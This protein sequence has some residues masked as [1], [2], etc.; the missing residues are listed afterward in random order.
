MTQ[1]NNS[2]VCFIGGDERQKYAAEALSEYVNVNAVGTAF[3]NIKRSNVKLFDNA[4]KAIYDTSAIILPLPAASSESEVPFA[5]LISA[6]VK[7]NDAPYIIGGKFSP[8]LKEIIEAYGINYWDYY[9]DEC[10]TLKNAFLTAEGAVHL[11]M[12]STKDA[13]RSSR[14][15]I[16]GYGRI[17]KALAEML[18]ALNSDTTVWARREDALIL[19]KEK[20]FKTAKI[21]GSEKNFSSLAK[22]YDIIFNTVPERILSND[23]LISIPQKTILV[24]LASAPGGFDPDIAMQCEL[25][26]VDGR[27]LPSKYAP[28]TAGEILADTISQHLKQRRN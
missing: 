25:K 24:E 20:R 11:A 12:S 23:L 1:K 2:T 6:V 15:A 4:Q 9:E 28:K 19:A 22:D 8:Y 14:C 3:E 10:F 18:N 26:F 7:L 16:I 27:G 17:G 13:L 21:T 5:E